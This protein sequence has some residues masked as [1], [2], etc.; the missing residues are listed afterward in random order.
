VKIRGK[1]GQYEVV[2]VYE[3]P[4][5]DNLFKG[6]ALR[7]ALRERHPDLDRLDDDARQRAVREFVESQASPVLGE[8]PYH[9][10]NPERAAALAVRLMH[11]GI[12]AKGMAAISDASANETVEVQAFVNSLFR[13]PITWRR[14]QPQLTD[15]PHR[16][17]ALKLADA[18][19]VPV[20]VS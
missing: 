13:E 19:A 12:A 20:R 14:G 10:G 6:C 2:S 15:G 8:C 3:L 7:D 1:Q 4:W 18:A 9:A 11:D 5:P 16:V 17:C